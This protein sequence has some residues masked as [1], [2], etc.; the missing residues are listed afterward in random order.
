[1]QTQFSAVS[2]SGANREALTR[3]ATGLSVANYPTIYRGFTEK[4]VPESEIR[5]RENVFTYRAWRELGRQ[6]RRGEHGVKVFTFVECEKK[7]EATG[8]V[9]ETYRRPWTTTVFH[10]SQTDPI[11]G[12]AQ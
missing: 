8:T 1:M 2:K 12:G 10:I 5:P 9:K 6:V 3:A 4:G 7:D 11:P